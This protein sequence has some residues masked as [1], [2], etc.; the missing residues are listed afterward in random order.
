MLN[1]CVQF[2][3][4]LAAL[5]AVKGGTWDSTQKGIHKLTP[6]GRISVLLI[7]VGFITSILLTYKSEQS[8]KEKSHQLIN[9]VKNTEEANKRLQRVQSELNKAVL[10]AENDN[11]KVLLSHLI[12]DFPTRFIWENGF[13]RISLENG[14]ACLEIFDYEKSVSSIENTGIGLTMC[15]NKDKN[16][17]QI[18]NL[19]KMTIAAS[20]CTPGYH[21]I[22]HDI[23][24]ELDNTVFE[25][26]KG[27]IEVKIEKPFEININQHGFKIFA[28]EIPI[29]VNWIEEITETHTSHRNGNTV[30]T[31]TG[32]TYFW[33]KE[34]GCPYFLILNKTYNNRY[35]LCNIRNIDG[36]AEFLYKK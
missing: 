11:F 22:Y 18:I 36:Y 4:F 32:D 28:P 19:E 25:K 13:L 31:P 20:L 35:V 21:F 24:I 7:I 14:G 17:M 33:I 26:N 2:I 9:A 12:V 10:L 1:Y 27:H 3:T 15:G 29:T 34:G 5:T 23:S 16:K 8:S 6:I 30:R